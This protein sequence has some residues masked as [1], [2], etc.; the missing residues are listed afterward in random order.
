MG[1]EL[2]LVRSQKL[3]TIGSVTLSVDWLIACF[4]Q[5]AINQ[6]THWLFVNVWRA[7]MKSAA[8]C[9]A[10]FWHPHGINPTS[11]SFG[12]AHS[13][14]LAVVEKPEELKLRRKKL[15]CSLIVM[16]AV[17]RKA[18]QISGGFLQFCC[19]SFSSVRS[20]PHGFLFGKT[21]KF[22]AE[23]FKNYVEPYCGHSFLIMVA[24]E[25]IFSW[26]LFV[27]QTWRL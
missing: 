21:E 27:R 11:H 17:F 19:S 25:F 9:C 24:S 26:D 8:S 3:Y 1:L 2:G 12:H 13:R 22:V 23:R 14:L 15:W 4:R 20:A 10:D 5:G 18:P 7:G 16:L 6:S